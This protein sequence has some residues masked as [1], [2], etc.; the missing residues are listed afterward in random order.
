MKNRRRR[1]KRR[2]KRI[3]FTAAVLLVLLT[4]AGLV[5]AQE[6]RNGQTREEELDQETQEAEHEKVPD[7]KPEEA[8][9]PKDS[10]ETELQEEARAQKERETFLADYSSAP[11]LETTPIRYLTIQVGATEDELRFN[12]MSPGSRAGKVSWS[13]VESGE[14]AVFDADCAQSQT[15]PGYYVNKATVTQ[16]QPGCTYVYRVGND[17]GGWSPEYQYTVPEKRSEGWTFLVTSDAQIGQAEMEEMSA[18]VERWDK[19]ITRLRDHVPEAE[20]MFHL[21]DQVAEYGNAEQYGGFLNHLGLYGIALAPVTGNHDVPNETSVKNTGAPEL[22]YF[23]EHFNVPNRSETIGMSAHDRDG[24]YCFVRGDVLFIVLNSST[25]QP[26][27]THEAFVPQAIA[28]YP[29]TKWRILVQH[30]PAYS[31]VLKYQNGLDEWIRKSLGYIAAD[32]EID[33]VLTGHDHQ[34]TRSY[35]TDR[36]CQSLPEYVYS[37]GSTAVN[38]TGTMYLTCSTASGCLYQKVTENVNLAFQGQ[39]EVPVAI[40]IDVS[41]TELHMK[42]YLMDSW[43][44]YDEY[45][46]RK[47]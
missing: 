31:G 37:S 36:Q 34:Y 28:Q 16:V 46:I 35:F 18:T 10:E 42:A 4:M 12:W 47:E 41:D 26:I 15:M 22:P 39:P 11:L 27:D 5:K 43:T 7:E 29:D 1:G 38:P 6:Y 17:E 19:V 25:I 44:L 23:Y 20:F 33:L 45:T 24:D 32:N 2:S 40:Q 14:T 9:T 13:C 8:D 3:V 21:G 30:Y